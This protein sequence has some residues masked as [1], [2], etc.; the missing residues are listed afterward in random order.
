MDQKTCIDPLRDVDGIKT[1][2]SILISNSM[3]PFVNCL[4]ALLS[5]TQRKSETKLPGGHLHEPDTWQTYAMVWHPFRPYASAVLRF[6]VTFPLGYPDLPPLVTFVTDIFHPLVTPLTTY[7]YSA[8]TSS[9]EPVGATNEER[10]PPGGFGLSDAFPCWF[11]RSERS[12]SSSNNSSKITSASYTEIDASDDGKLPS[13]DSEIEPSSAHRPS[14]H[15]IALVL[16][17]MRRAFDDEELLNRLPAKAAAN[18]GA[19]KAWQ[20]RYRDMPSHARLEEPL[21]DKSSVIRGRQEVQGSESQAKHPSDWSWEGVWER[22][23]RKG[24]AASISDQVLF[25]GSGGEETIRFAQIQEDTV[26]VLKETISD[27]AQ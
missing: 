19:W 20:V 6:D 14:Q 12:T 7:T 25:G 18:P 21:N 5:R 16:D 9:S 23:V 11:R 3:T 22:R 27:T 8:G 2:S 17:Y 15:P 13:R 1:P 26:D 10:L 4:K 24:I